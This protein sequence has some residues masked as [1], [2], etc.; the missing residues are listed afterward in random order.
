MA[1]GSSSDN[2]APAPGDALTTTEV[3]TSDWPA[4]A[5]E[6]IERVVGQVRDMT[7][8]RA[9]TAARALVYGTFALLLG[10]AVVVLLAISAVRL[11]DVY[12]PDAVFGEDHTWVAHG[13]VGGVLTIAGMVLWS[14][15]SGGPSRDAE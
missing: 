3:D 10:T 2:R 11:L 14:R 6:T 5:A 15:R 4:Q 12:L 9:I 8:G 7:T 1:T 13:L